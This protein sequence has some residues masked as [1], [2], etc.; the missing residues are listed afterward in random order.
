MSLHHRDV[1]R[2]VPRWRV[3]AA[4]DTALMLTTLFA[5]LVIPNL[6]NMPDGLGGFLSLRITIKNVVILAVL[7]G[8]WPLVFHTSGVYRRVRRS[9]EAMRIVIACAL[10]SWMAMLFSV[11]SLSGRFSTRSVV[12]FWVCSTLSLFAA[13]VVRHY[14]TKLSPRAQ[15]V[16]IVGLGPRGREAFRE[17][18][19]AAD[20]K[21]EVI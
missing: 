15:R 18:Q 12:A 17:L 13:R 2:Y 7:V 10:T 11:T 1:G 19:T 8:V 4:G 20:R 21:Y 5:V 9:Q 14:H 6:D 3:R 16:V